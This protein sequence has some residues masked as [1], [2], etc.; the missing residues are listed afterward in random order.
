MNYNKIISHFPIENRDRQKDL[1]LRLR[2]TRDRQNAHHRNQQI[3]LFPT[4]YL[5]EKEPFQNRLAYSKNR[6]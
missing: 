1:R 2:L 5:F 4:S 3:A 6:H